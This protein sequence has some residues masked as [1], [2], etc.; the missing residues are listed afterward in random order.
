M[1]D[2]DDF[3]GLLN[4]LDILQSDILDVW[5]KIETMEREIRKIF[6]GEDVCSK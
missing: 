3:A 5:G 1:K 6:K 4:D 2:K